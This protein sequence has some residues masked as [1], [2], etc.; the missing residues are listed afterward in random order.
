[1]VRRTTQPSFKCAI[2]ADRR[3]FRRT[4]TAFSLRRRAALCCTRPSKSE[5]RRSAG[6]RQEALVPPGG[7]PAPPECR[8]AKPTRGR[9]TGHPRELPAHAQEGRAA[10]P[11]RALPFV[12]LP[13]RLM[14]APLGGRGDGDIVLD[15]NI[16]NIPDIQP[17]NWPAEQRTLSYGK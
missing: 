7:A 13:R 6:S 3:V 5:E 15:R 17:Q 2:L 4:M 10:K 14:R 1:M 8:L 11:R 16:V 9:R 12:P